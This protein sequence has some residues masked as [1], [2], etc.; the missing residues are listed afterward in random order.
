V[1]SRWAPLEYTPTSTDSPPATPS[2]TPPAAHRLPDRGL[3]ADGPA[4]A[5]R[6]AGRKKEARAYH[7]LIAAIAIGSYLPLFTCNLT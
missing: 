2:S 5:M 7:A 6:T 1:G 3:D 4:G